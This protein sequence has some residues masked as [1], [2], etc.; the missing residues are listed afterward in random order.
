VTLVACLIVAFL[1]VRR[2]AAIALVLASPFSFQDIRWVQTGFLSASLLGGALLALERRP[3]LAGVLI[4]L[5]AYKPQFGVL[6]PLALVAAAEWRAITAAAATVGVLA[7]V[8][9]AAFGIGPWAAFPHQLFAQAG[10]VLLGGA[11]RQA[12][13]HDVQTFYGL[14]HALH[15]GGTLAW[16]IQGGVTA[17]AAMTVWLVW[18]SPARFPLKAASLSAATLIA[19]PYAWAHDLTAIVVPVAFLA[20]DQAESGLLPGEQTVLLALFALAFATFVGAPVPPVGPVIV[21]A[22]LGIV[23]RR[24]CRGRRLDGRPVTA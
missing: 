18:R 12:D 2:W 4:G 15:G 7:G 22:V 8:S 10:G 3:A 24:V 16:P 21:T 17:A 9:I 11:Q 20:R 23:L 1:I 6:I 13:W 14:V 19:T 5:L